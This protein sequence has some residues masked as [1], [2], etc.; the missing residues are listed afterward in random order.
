MHFLCKLVGF[1]GFP[2]L[3][4]PHFRGYT[5]SSLFKI[6]NLT[7]E[8]RRTQRSDLF[9]LA[10]RG[11]QIKNPLSYPNMNCLQPDGDERSYESTSE[12]TA[13][14]SE[15][16]QTAE[17]CRGCFKRTDGRIEYLIGAFCETCR[18]ERI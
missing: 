2:P 6:G 16:K 12:G 1:G 4:I 8:A 11:R 13:L 17:V 7:A 9:C 14:S 15:T 5:V 10:V 18:P 3:F